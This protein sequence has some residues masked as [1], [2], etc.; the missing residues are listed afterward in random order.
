[1]KTIGKETIYSQRTDCSMPCF[2][3][4]KSN[5]LLRIVCVQK[6]LAAKPTKA[7][8]SV[9]AQSKT[10]QIMYSASPHNQ[11]PGHVITCF[12]LRLWEAFPVGRTSGLL[13]TELP[14]QSHRWP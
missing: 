1:M 8:A 13:N 2:L 7:L 10:H 11:S 4:G 12:L 9:P 5:D 14:S 6:S 3:C